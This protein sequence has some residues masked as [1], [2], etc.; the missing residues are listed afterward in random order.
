MHEIALGSFQAIVYGQNNKVWSYLFEGHA[1]FAFCALN[2][3]G[4]GATG[5]NFIFGRLKQRGAWNHQLLCMETARDL[6]YFWTDSSESLY[7]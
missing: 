5:Y 7:K 2:M 1:G 4:F 6:N 3:I